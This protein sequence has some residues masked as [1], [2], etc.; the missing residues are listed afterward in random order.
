MLFPGSSLFDKAPPWIVA[1]EMIRTS[2]LFARTAAKINPAWLEELGGDL[3][4]RSYSNPHWDRKRGEVRAD[5]SVTL[6]G[7]EIVSERKVSYG[8][9]NPEEAHDI[10]IM[11]ALV[12]GDMDAKP[13]FLQHNLDLYSRMIKME[14]KL[15]RRGIGVSEREI[16]DFYSRRLKGITNRRS[17][18]ARIKERG[19]DFLRMKEQ[20]V[21]RSQPDAEELRKFPDALNIGGRCFPTA[22]KFIPGEKKDGVTLKVPSDLLE[23][24]PRESID[25]G[26]AGQLQERIAALIKGLPKRYRKQLVPVP[27]TS[28]IIARE[29]EME[30]GSIFQAL[31]RF[32]RKRFNADIPP[33]AWEQSRIPPH[34]KMRIAVTDHTGREIK[35]GRDLDTLK[36]TVS[37]PSAPDSSPAWDKAREKWEQTGLT[38]WNFGDLPKCIQLGPFLNAYPGLEPA[39]N[40]VNLRLYR[41]PETARRM[42]LRGVE[43]LLRRQRK[44][45]LEFTG[46]FLQIPEEYHSAAL[47]FGGEN[48]L[49]DQMKKALIKNVFRREIREEAEF[50]AHTYHA[51]RILLEEGHD[52]RDKIIRIL[53]EYLK[54]RKLIKEEKEKCGPKSPVRDFVQEILDDLQSLVPEHFIEAYPPD[55]LTHLSRYMEAMRVRLERGINNLEKDRQ[56]VSQ[57]A[58]FQKALLKL[59]EKEMTAERKDKSR[60]IEKLRWLLEEF[61]VALFAPELGTAVTV[62]PKRLL[63]K[64]RQIQL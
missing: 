10:F 31:S 3:C 35:A 49:I 28:R 38:E 60:E 61:K 25:W 46:K 58:G 47:F 2:R 5:E 50:K 1:A 43:A 27:D 48:A 34:L 16:F 20:D 7:L 13:G 21:L 11:S 18:E 59:Q 40:G 52:L 54:T 26:V 23:E 63:E 4:R 41:D 57:M 6:Y 37:V 42:H 17:L 62:S 53:G 51:D 44:G 15:R 36:K 55:R 19:D 12:E 29:I 9:I 56:K 33:K 24:I 64:I 32:V 39:E 22:Y 8:R 45:E 30:A 14:D